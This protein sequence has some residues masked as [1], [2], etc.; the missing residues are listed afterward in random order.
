MLR[1]ISNKKAQAIMGEYVVTFFLVIGF[2]TAMTVYLKRALQSYVRDARLEMGAVVQN[3]TTGVFFVGNIFTEYEPYYLNQRSVVNRSGG[4]VQSLGPG[5]TTGVYRK[6]F[7]EQ[8]R[9]QSISNTIPP[10]L[11]D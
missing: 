7:G 9:T 10:Q 11:A 6:D 8:T 3:R 5:G 1:I 4:T 2:M